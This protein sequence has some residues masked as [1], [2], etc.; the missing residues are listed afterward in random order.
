M[1]G[2][3][4]GPEHSGAF[5]KLLRDRGIP[6]QKGEAGTHERLGRLDRF[7]LSLRWLIGDLFAATDSQVWYPHLQEMIVNYNTRPHRGL[8]PVGKGL[9]PIDIGAREEEVLRRHD[10]EKA[11]AV[12]KRTDKSGVGPGTRVRVL[13]QRLKDGRSKFRKSSEET[14]SSRVYTVVER[15]GPN[16]F[17]VD[18]E[19][20]QPKVWPLYTL[21][22]VPDGTHKKKEAGPKVDR[23]VVSAQRLENRNISPRE[24]AEALAAPARPKRERK[25]RVDYAKLAGKGRR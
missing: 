13:A 12:R 8:A 14:W 16:S 7:H 24:R 1:C 4:G 2:R 6:L 23:K 5:A 22:P 20:G 18:T 15:A 10:S 3:M 19:S 11:L 9:A 21:Q 25:P 17:M